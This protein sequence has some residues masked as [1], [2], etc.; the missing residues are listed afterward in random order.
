M[1]DAADGPNGP[2]GA[3]RQSAG[4]VLVGVDDGSGQEPVLRH[5]ARHAVLHGSPLRVLHVVE[6]RTAADAGAEVVG[7][8]EKLVRSEFPGLPVTAEAVTGRAAAVLLERSREAAWLVVGHRGSGGFPRLPLGSV[9]WQVA[10][11]AECPVI[12]IRSAELPEA[13]ANRVVAGVDLSQVSEAALDVAYA[14]AD[15]RGARLELVHG[16]FHLGEMP[17]GPSMTQ[18][19]FTSMDA[20]ARTAL[21]TEAA[22]R[23]ERFPRVRVDVRVECLRPAT[24]LADASRGAAL[25]VVGSHG[26]TGL[27]RLLL[28]SVSG[29]VLHTASCPVVVV[30]TTTVTD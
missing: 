28:G 24:L 26:R 8:L 7:R 12:V 21:E 14:E 15:L 2:N 25:L 29:E 27:R 22:G 23:R 9:S 10:T 30:P 19:D 20:S 13:P 16:S 11:H 17:S 3:E 4:A 18:P 5:A 1:A 6:H